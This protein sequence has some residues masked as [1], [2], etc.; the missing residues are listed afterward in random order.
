MPKQQFRG[1]IASRTNIGDFLTRRFGSG[2]P[3]HPGD[4]KVG[5]VDGA[6]G[7]GEEDIGG[8]NVAVNN[9]QGMKMC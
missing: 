7:G 5:D 1:S 9:A 3:R 8:L 6:G 4:A 2:I